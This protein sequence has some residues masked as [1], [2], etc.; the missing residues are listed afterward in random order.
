MCELSAALDPRPDA[1]QSR[2]VARMVLD[3][4]LLAQRRVGLR[5]VRRLLRKRLSGRAI[6]DTSEAVDAEAVVRVRLL[7]VD[8]MSAAAGLP[9]EA[10]AVLAQRWCACSSRRLWSAATRRSARRRSARRRPTWSSGRASALKP[11]KSR[12]SGCPLSSRGPS[13]SVDTVGSS[14]VDM[15]L[16]PFVDWENIYCNDVV[17]VESTLGIS[18]AAAVLYRELTSVISFDGTYVFPGTCSSSWTR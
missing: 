14:L 17:E 1:G 15:C 16:I 18:A 9:A 12:P 11:Q 4:R 13:T 6:V 5:E 2:F 10:E 8:D 3:S 7:D